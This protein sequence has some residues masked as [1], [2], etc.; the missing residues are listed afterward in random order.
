MLF[1]F[2]VA[3]DCSEFFIAV[4]SV[5]D[6]R[7]AIDL[8]HPHWRRLTLVAH[9]ASLSSFSR[10]IVSVAFASVVARYGRSSAPERVLQRIY[11]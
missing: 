9:T 3:A 5:L 10:R 7:C 6:R 2:F 11:I 4:G 1:I 8:Q